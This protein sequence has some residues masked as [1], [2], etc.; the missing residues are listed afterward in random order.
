MNSPKGWFRRFFVQDKRR[1]KRRSTPQLVA[2]YWTG[3]APGATGVQDI[4]VGGLYLLTEERWYPGTLIKMTLQRT[5]SA[6]DGSERF[7]IVQ[8][9]A[10]RWGKDGVGLEFVLTDSEDSRDNDGQQ[11][12]VLADEKTLKRFLRRLWRSGR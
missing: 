9:K 3:A 8:S 11:I 2:H 7:I 6:D 12:N 10:V 4:S 1:A 5:D